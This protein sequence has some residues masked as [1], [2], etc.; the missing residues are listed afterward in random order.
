MTL[1]R[2]EFDVLVLMAAANTAGQSD[3]APGGGHSADVIGTCV[4]RLEGMGYV[5]DGRLTEAG[6]AALVPY[7]VGNAVIMAAG[8][9][10]RFAPISYEKPKGLLRVRGEVLIE[11]QIRQLH[12][13][14]IDDITVVVGY[15]GEYFFYLAAKFG[16]GIMVN[17]D[18]ATR[19]N[20]ST[21]WVARAR[22][23]N[24]FVCSSDNYFIENP[25]EAY[26]YEAYYSTQYMDGPTDEWCVTSGSDGVITGMHVGGADSWVM[27]GHVY[28]DQAFSTAFRGILEREYHLP[29][30]APKL[31]E[32][33]Y[34]EHVAELR[35]VARHYPDGAI[36]EFDSL[37]ELRGFDD[38]FIENVDSEAL[39]NIVTILGCEKS[40]ISDFYPLKQG[41]TN[42]SCHFTVGDQEYV[43]RHP[44]AGTEKII[45][46]KAEAKALRLARKLGLD[47]TFLHADP[48][49]GWKVSRFLRDVRI[50]DPD[51]PVERR[52]AMEMVRTL[53]Q[54]GKKLKNTFS[55][56]T[57]SRT[58]EEILRTYGPIDVPGFFDLKDKIARLQAFVDA[59]A[60]RRPPVPSHN[61]FYAP[62]LLIDRAGDIHLIDWEYAG[63][64]D[65]ANDFGTFAVCSEY[66][67]DQAAVALDDYFGR[68][69][70]LTERRRFFAHIV[71]AGWYWYVWALVKEAEGEAVGDWLYIFYRP[72]ADHIDLMLSWYQDATLMA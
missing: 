1:T 55:Y 15:K 62:N 4:A 68:P 46:R 30:T 53:H 21:L 35:M 32:A 14:G 61:D 43:Y 51:N 12:E 25:F 10:E 19:N 6:L 26:V 8:M 60:E 56:E 58:C 40:S 38:T 50:L 31:W 2:E 69:A 65:E 67:L 33:L 28:F 39:D 17:A 7:K 59:D 66:S 5:A 57:A 72:A 23:G 36:H 24:T 42:L 54:S 16:V 49:R 22:L 63:M 11:R 44:G 45:D 34:Q 13:A 70:T 37:D 29:T 41:L 47:A 64:S 18:Y 9:S 48:K 3:P 27:L 20:N 52:A 71:L